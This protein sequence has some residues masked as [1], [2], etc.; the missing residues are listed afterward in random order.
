MAKH[1]PV[2]YQKKQHHGQAEKYGLAEQTFDT[3]LAP[4]SAPQHPATK[5]GAGAK[6]AGKGGVAPKAPTAKK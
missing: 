2:G 5:V 4:G 3:N 6:D 1:V